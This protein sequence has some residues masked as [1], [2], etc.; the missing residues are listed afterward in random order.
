MK[1]PKKGDRFSRPKSGGATVSGRILFS[2][3]GG[4]RIVD[5]KGEAVAFVDQ[6]SLGVAL[7]GDTVEAKCS[8]RQGG[9]GSW[10]PDARVLRV[11]KRAGSTMVGTLQFQKKFMWL[12]P[13]DARNPQI[14]ITGTDGVFPFPPKSGDKI[15]VRLDEWK[16]PE[17][18]P[19]GVILEVLGSA[20]APGVDMESVIR[21]WNLPREFPEEVL[22]EA[23]SFG[24]AID[25]DELQHREDC[26]EQ[27]VLTIDPDDAKDH[28]DAIHVT[29]LEDGW[30]LVVHIADVAH[31]VRPDSAL[32]REAKHRGNSTYLP[33]RCIPMLPLELSAGLCSLHAKVDRLAHSAFVTLTA[34]GKIKK[35][36]FA[37]T[38]IRVAERLTYK[39]AMK[40][41][42]GEGEGRVPEQV[43]LAWQLASILR[44]NRFAAGSLDLD[45]PEVKVLLDADG[46]AIGLEK[47]AYD[48]SHQLVEECMLTA[49]EVVAKAIRDRETPGVYRI[50]EKPD[51]DR[52]EEYR[53]F[54]AAQGYRVGDLKV[55]GE[56]QKL[57]SMIRGKPDEH[58]VKLELLK[59]L[60]RAA[61]SVDPLGHYGLSKP[62]YTHFTSPI[63]RFADLVVHRVLAKERLGSGGSRKGLA[64]VCEHISETERASA[65]AEKDGS[66]IKKVEFFQRQ[67]EMLQ[68]DE[69]DAIVTDVKSAGLLIELPQADM[70]GFIQA[71]TLPG[72]YYD[73]DRVRLRFYDRRTQRAFGIG[74]RFKVIVCRVDG[75]RKQV[76]FAPAPPAKQAKKA[77][78]K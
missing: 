21:T 39:Q 6:D 76:D 62:N 3:R 43:R 16:N 75:W 37:K 10:L 59:S 23:R 22:Q 72:G 24:E 58:R 9:G 61:Y 69:F 32:D 66:M 44:K 53:Q 71:S 64:E 52:L 33:D 54:A 46:H 8:S 51:P 2:Q 25:A 36:R 47:I 48:E 17:A 5:E 19:T 70:T 26:R 14:S 68:P 45:F 18:I 29:K 77:G 35:V 63:R 30:L 38:V 65:S 12:I 15:V 41:I 78:E 57:I 50:H 73:F 27:L 55:R 34:T 13:D 60:R 20:G 4:G 28:D 74:D 11:L 31:Y 42:S 67:I 40:M 49:N 1:Q 56:I 7:H